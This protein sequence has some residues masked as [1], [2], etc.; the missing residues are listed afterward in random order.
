MSR[1]SEHSPAKQP[2]WQMIAPLIEGSGKTQVEI[3]LALG[4]PNANIIT[5]FK[6][7]TTR[8]PA[9]KVVQ[10]ALA[11]GQDPRALLR[12]WFKTYMSDVFPEITQYLGGAISTEVDAA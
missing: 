7:G 10:F 5:M 1:Q 8:M 3:A 6:K 12:E 9:N 4:Y 2:F 11:V